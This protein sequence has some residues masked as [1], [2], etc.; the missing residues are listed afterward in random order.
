MNEDTQE[1]PRVS[2]SYSLSAYQI[3]K[4]LTLTVLGSFG[5]L[6]A[7]PALAD[8]HA[9][10]A[11]VSAENIAKAGENGF[12]PLLNGDSLDGWSVKGSKATFTV[13]DGEV[14][15]TARNLKGN[16]FLCSD[17]L[18]GDFIF[19]FQMKFDNLKGNSGCMFRGQ[20]SEKGRV[21]GYQCEHDNTKRSW[22]AGIYDEARRGWICPSKKKGDPVF[23]SFREAFT[24]QGR[25]LFK[26]DD[27]NTIVIQ[28]KGDEVK[29]W[30][31][32]EI[33]LQFKESD[34]EIAK[35]KGFFGLQVHGGGSCDVRWKNLFVKE[36]GGEKKAE[37]K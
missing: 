8:H 11:P 10:A 26:E 13:K 21:K 23:E 17:K 29:I 19:A 14:F 6:A 35:Q 25:R 1:W 34:K 24:A 20:L 30:L 33:R 4:K 36:L 28:C 18:Y 22:T 16:S 31:N 15:G 32:D 27:W 5:L 3:M 9:L 2:N 37:K 7:T 12:T